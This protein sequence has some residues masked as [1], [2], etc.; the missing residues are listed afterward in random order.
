MRPFRISE[1]IGDSAEEIVVDGEA[2]VPEDL[3]SRDAA[4]LLRSVFGEP[5]YDVHL[6]CLCIM[7]KIFGNE[8][9]VADISRLLQP[10]SPDQAASRY[11]CP[12]RA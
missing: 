11:R 10:L 8:S 2:T 7:L 3:G 12:P 4:A 9:S 5:P 1:A 6:L